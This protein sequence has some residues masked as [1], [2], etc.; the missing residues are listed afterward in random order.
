MRSSMI[1]LTASLALASCAND[2]PDAERGAE[3][4]LKAKKEAE[5]EAKR[6]LM[7]EEREKAAAREAEM[8]TARRKQAEEGQSFAV[9]SIT[10]AADEDP[11]ALVAE[12]VELMGGKK[13]VGAVETISGTATLT[14][15]VDQAYDFVIEYP[16]K[17][18]VDFKDAGGQVTR[19]LLVDGKKAY[20]ITRGRVTELVNP[21]LSDTLLSI[22]GD[23]LCLMIALAT[24]G[25]GHDLTY[26]GRAEV[27]GKLCDAVRVQPPASK[28]IIA[29]FDAATGRLV[30]TRYEMAQGLVTVIDERFEEIGGIEIGVAGKQIIGPMVSTVTVTNVEI[31]PE[32]PKGMFEPM[33]HRLIR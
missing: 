10:K 2:A 13:T 11:S 16:A 18:V 32:L 29:F 24:G 22:R 15:A 27:A 21:T 30:A 5:L 6:R 4:A 33:Q 23:P 25:E 26:L 28:E 17:M 1:V 7:A 3:D 12:A 20:N 8:K 19:A 14:G 31:N 9:G